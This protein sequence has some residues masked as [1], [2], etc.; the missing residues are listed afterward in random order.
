M[1]KTKILAV[2][3]EE[4]HLSVLEM[5]LAKAGYSVVTADN[6]KDALLLANTEPPDLIILDLSMPD[7]DGTEVAEKLKEADATNDIPI[8]FLTGLYSKDQEN[9]RGNLI[10]GNMMLA[11][12]YDNKKLFEL[13]SKLLK[14][15]ASQEA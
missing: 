6:G 14:D 1:S 3:D 15:H 13:I 4:G 2:D 11:K 5:T 12:P 8:L 10:A 9:K 7:M